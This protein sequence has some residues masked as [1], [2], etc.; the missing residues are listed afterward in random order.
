MARRAASTFP[1]LPGLEPAPPVIDAVCAV[2][3]ERFGPGASAA[4]LSGPLCLHDC[5]NVAIGLDPGW[6]IVSHWEY[7]AILDCHDRIKMALTVHV[8]AVDAWASDPRRSAADVVEALRAVAP[9]V[10]DVSAPAEVTRRQYVAKTP[11]TRRFL[12]DV[13]VAG[14]AV[15]WSRNPGVDLSEALT[16]LRVEPTHSPWKVLSLV[17]RRIRR[18]RLNE[19]F[20]TTAADLLDRTR[21]LVR[22]GGSPSPASLLWRVASSEGG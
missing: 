2:V 8:G 20:E 15:W 14:V 7:Q 17:D 12:P 10:T 21:R 6:P 13:A 22:A 19:K 4:R 16:R 9:L 11:V 3:E 18:T 1:H 5:V